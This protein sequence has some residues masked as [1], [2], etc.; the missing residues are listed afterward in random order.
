MPCDKIRRL[1]YRAC[2][3]TQCSAGAFEKKNEINEAAR[4]GRRYQFTCSVYGCL[5]YYNCF[6]FLKN[7]SLQS[8][9][10]TIGINYFGVLRVSKAMF[11]L[12]RPHARVVQVSSAMGHLSEIPGADLKARLS[13]PDLT[14]DGLSQLMRDFVE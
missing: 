2:V 9:S 7:K 8:P 13:S 14:E 10:Q 4:F 6:V 11:P 12:L 3:N 1:H 5:R